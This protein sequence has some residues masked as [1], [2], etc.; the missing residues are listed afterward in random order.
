M[1]YKLY[2]NN[3][4]DNMILGDPVI[5]WVILV[6]QCFPDLRWK[7]GTL[8]VTCLVTRRTHVCMLILA[9]DT[10][11]QWHVFLKFRV[12]HLHSF[13]PHAPT[14]I[15][16]VYHWSVCAPHQ[17][18]WIMQWICEFKTGWF[19]T[20]FNRYVSFDMMIFA[21][22]LQNTYAVSKNILTKK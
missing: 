6:F 9:S 3:A 11:T 8:L 4:W 7:G 15:S 21:V 17:I 14:A 22:A 1:G 13:W 12:Q 19:S 2:T 20:I 10:W 5:C 16:D 18:G